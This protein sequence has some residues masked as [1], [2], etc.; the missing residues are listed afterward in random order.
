MTDLAPLLPDVTHPLLAP[1]WE[2]AARHRLAIPFCAGCGAAQ[3]PPRT[4][5]PVCRSF[6][7]EWREVDPR[8][9]LFSYFVA[10]KPLHPSVANEVPYAA[11]VVELP[12][13]VKML[14]RLV[15]I[16]HADIR[17][18]MPVRASFVERAPGVT[19]VFWEADADAPS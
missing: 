9:N 18:G 8:G 6:D 12:A 5:C 13:G 15:G 4:N 2:A 17:L 1:H 19:L 3:W 7:M 14:G 10:H 16:D 11:G